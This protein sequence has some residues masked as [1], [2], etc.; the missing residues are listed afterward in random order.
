MLGAVGN[1]SQ[2]LCEDVSMHAPI[3]L[4]LKCRVQRKPAAKARDDMVFAASSGDMHAAT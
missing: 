2:D 1:L 3:E 4:A